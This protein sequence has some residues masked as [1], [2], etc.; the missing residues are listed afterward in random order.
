MAGEERSQRGEQGLGV[1]GQDVLG[2][3]SAGQEVQLAR[4][5]REGVEPPRGIGGDEPAV[6]AVGDQ[7]WRGGNEVD[8]PG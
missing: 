2:V 1:V 6:G 8:E 5:P 4:L 3:Q 7:Q